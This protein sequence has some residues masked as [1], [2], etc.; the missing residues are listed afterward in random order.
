MLTILLPAASAIAAQAEEIPPMTEIRLIRKLGEYDQAKEYLNVLLEDKDT[1]DDIRAQVY[2]ELITI[3]ILTD[4][5]DKARPIALKAL[6]E[7][8]NL[9]ADHAHHPQE[10]FDLYEE[11]RK[12]KFGEL[13]L[14]TDP[15]GCDVYLDGKHVGK[16]PLKS[17]HV[18]PGKHTIRFSRYEY[19]EETLEIEV[20]AGEESTHNVA[21]ISGSTL[22]DKRF[23]FEFGI[24]NVSLKYGSGSDFAGV[25]EASSYSSVN[26]L[27]G[28]LF[29][30][31]S[32]HDRL[33]LQ[34]GFRYAPMG[35]MAYY[36]M[37]SPNPSG[38]YECKMSYINMP[39]LFKY[40]LSRNPGFVIIA[41]PEIGFLT[42]A[43]LS[44]EN[45]SGS[46]DIKPE[47]PAIE[48]FL[49]I[50]LGL[51]KKVGD[52]ISLM[53]NGYFTIGL[54]NLRNEQRYETIEFKPQEFRVSAGMM[55]H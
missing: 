32:L 47:L 51:E 7:I 42:S 21:L 5:K 34:I 1:P 48:L 24:S 45:G 30:Q 35:N 39:I 2:N 41:G 17:L 27:S 14:T 49:T 4:G 33:A 40:Y 55:F 19:K 53:L 29:M 8:P 46:I 50:G 18:L 25:G 12:S 37:Y 31:A 20:T 10:V 23:G 9:E 11:I 3:V 22:R 52:K 15:P 13:N 28:G 43:K 44:A 36:D 54:S 26:R 38:K 16:T 6:E